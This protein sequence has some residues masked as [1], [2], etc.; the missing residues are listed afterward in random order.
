MKMIIMFFLLG[1]A[2]SSNAQDKKG[3]HLPMITRSIG[4]SYQQFDGINS[5]I[6]GLPQYKKLNDYA[7][8][9][10]L[11]WLHEEKRFISA[12][13]LTVGSSMSGDR[14]KKSSSIRFISVSMD[15]GY[16]LLKSEKI[17]LYPLAGLGFQ[18]YQ[19]IFYKDNS[20]VNFNDVLIS[21][22]VQN[23]ISSVKFNNAFLVYRLGFGFSVKSPK[24][25]SSSIGIQ[26]GYSG[27]FKDRNWRSNENQ[28]LG[29]APEDKISQFFL[30]LV[31][32][33]KPMFMR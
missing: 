10:G 28:V 31:F 20:A 12:G 25:P 17:M 32:T 27:S 14:D 22:E 9:L 13:G 15:L 1:V 2:F 33:C 21:P 16:D 23:N 4:V 19:A 26:G 24:H 7:A 30:G 18:G 3:I 8:T 11:G 6:A 29:N 5:R